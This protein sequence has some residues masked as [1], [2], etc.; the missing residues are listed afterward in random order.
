MYKDT[1]FEGNVN[2]V[3]GIE[4]EQKGAKYRTLRYTKEDIEVPIEVLEP[5]RTECDRFV[6]KLAIQRRAEAII[7][8]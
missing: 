7:P 4:D 8:N 2:N 3:R 6:K 5:S 1:V